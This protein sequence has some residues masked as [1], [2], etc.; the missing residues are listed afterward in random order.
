MLEFEQEKRQALLS[1]DMDRLEAMIQTQ[2]ASIMKLESLEKQR[3]DAQERAGFG[4]MPAVEILSK[5]HDGPEKAELT[6]HVGDLKQ[7]LEDIRFHNEKSLEIARANLNLISA[8]TSKQEHHKE[9]PGTYR[10]GQIGKPGWDTSA[11]FDKKF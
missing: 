9:T 5:M 10:P 7:T 2:Q 8:L 3:L 4:N 11:T 6:R 1:D